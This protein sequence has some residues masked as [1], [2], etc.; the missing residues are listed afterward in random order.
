MVYRV[1]CALAHADRHDHRRTKENGT[2][3]RDCSRCKGTCKAPGDSMTTDY[4]KEY[5]VEF[6]PRTDVDIT[7]LEWWE[8]LQR[9]HRATKA[10]AFSP[11]DRYLTDTHAME[12]VGLTIQRSPFNRGFDY[13][14]GRPMN[15]SFHTRHGQSWV[16]GTDLY[17]QHAQIPARV[18][19]S[20]LR[21][22]KTRLYRAQGY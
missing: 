2:E 10:P 11:H 16:R 14:N 13:V 22:E 7:G 21:R 6:N 8:V 4:R 20:A 9:L 18:T 1:E 12:L 15:V 3:Y 5:G 19:I 17:D